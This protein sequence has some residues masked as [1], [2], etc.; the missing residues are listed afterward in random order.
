MFL[1]SL[2]ETSAGEDSWHFWRDRRGNRVE[3]GPGNWSFPCR[4][5]RIRV[6]FR[7]ER[8]TL[9]LMEVSYRDRGNREESR[10][11]LPNRKRMQASTCG[12]FQR[13]ITRRLLVQ[14][15]HQQLNLAN[16]RATKREFRSIAGNGFC[17]AVPFDLSGITILVHE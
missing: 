5:S 6:F 14:T 1:L 11:V 13:G 12:H 17:L 4:S 16:V 7:N 9:N 10:R 15:D 3:T 2:R 8:S